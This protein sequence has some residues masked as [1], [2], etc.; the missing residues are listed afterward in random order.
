MPAQDSNK[1]GPN[2][3]MVDL[4]GQ[5]QEIKTEIDKAISDAIISSKFINGPQVSEFA[6]KLASYTGSKYVIPCANGTDALQVAMMALGFEPGDEVIVPAFTYV[7]AVE[8]IALLGLVPRF[9]DVDPDTF[10][11]D[12]SQIEKSITPRTRGIV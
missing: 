1:K 4:L 9:V 12:P 6:A 10:N 5:Y 3:Q 2:I 7:S 11:I 8:T